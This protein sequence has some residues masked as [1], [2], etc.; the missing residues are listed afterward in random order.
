MK[1]LEANDWERSRKKEGKLD[2]KILLKIYVACTKH[3][4]MLRVEFRFTR[5]FI[6]GFSVHVFFSL[7]QLSTKWQ[8]CFKN[9]VIFNKRIYRVMC[10]VLVSHVAHS[11]LSSIRHFC[12]DAEFDL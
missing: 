6:L 2:I 10:C 9:A 3:K 7:S 1:R 5:R 12:A 4:K 8:K 11:P